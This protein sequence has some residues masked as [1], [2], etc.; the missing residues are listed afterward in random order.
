MVII[1]LATLPYIHKIEIIFKEPGT[2][3]DTGTGLP[4]PVCEITFNSF[5]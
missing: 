2:D 1:A 3:I 5:R 4:V